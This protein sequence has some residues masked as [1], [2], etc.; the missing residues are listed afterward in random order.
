MT[1]LN[2]RQC[3]V[4]SKKITFKFQRCSPI[5]KVGAHITICNITKPILQLD[6]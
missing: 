6:E 2:Y 4:H 3:Q 5:Y 1:F